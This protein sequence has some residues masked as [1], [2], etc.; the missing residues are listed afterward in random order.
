M[1]CA[2]RAFVGQRDVDPGLA[3]GRRDRLQPRQ[4]AAGE[5]HGRP[6]ARQ[7]DHA[8]VAPEHAAAQAG[9]ERLGAGLL[10]GEALGV[11]FRA[12][13]A[14]LGLG[15]LGRR[16][17]AVEKALAVALEHLLDAAHVAEIGAEAD[18]H[19]CAGF[20]SPAVHGRAHEF[21][22]LGQALEH[23]LADQEMPDIEFDDLRQR[24]DGLGARIVE[25]VAGM[26]FQAEA[27]RQQRAGADQLPF[28][29]GLARRVPR[30]AR[31]T[32]RRCESRSPARPARPPPRS[33]PAARR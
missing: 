13:G 17:D 27:L 19:G 6:S 32:R 14:A 24:R 22:G 21:D 10:G 25:A 1:A 4:R 28:G 2:S 26:H 33:A 11:G 5:L 18:D 20:G 31:R 9:A 7:I 29:I 8:H 12:I 23:R 15:A 3:A 16:E 30:P